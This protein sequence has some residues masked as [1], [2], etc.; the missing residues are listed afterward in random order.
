M[1]RVGLLFLGLWLLAAAQVV[2]A[3]EPEYARKQDVIYGR[4]YGLALTLDVFSPKTEPNGAGAILVASGGYFSSPDMINPIF[5]SELLKRGYTVFVV[6]HGSQPKFTLTEIVEDMH[7]AV[8]YIRSHAKEYGVDPQRL[9]IGGASA[10][11]HLSLMMGTAGTQGDPKA[12]DPVDRESSRVQAVACF[13]P[14]TDFLNW[15]KEGNELLGA[16]AH[17][18]R[19]RATF[20]HH[21]FDKKE[22]L[23][24]PVTDRQ[25]LRE[26]TKQV[27]P[28]WHVTA[29][30]APTLLIH[31]D[32]DDLVP[33]Q[34]SELMAAKLKGAK[35]ASELQVRKGAGHGWLTIAFD[36]KLFA[37]WY[38]K[39]LT[40]K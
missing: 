28:A 31:G 2:C 23:F 26:I 8:R 30:D 12:A 7:R 38:D 27:S 9:A 5:Y 24:L 29:D 34:Q 32:K 22:G 1:P 37:D 10:G 13:F 11:G 14:P 17:E 16:R 36:M 18:V 21:L 6:V 20:D 39:H 19:F 35:V 40:K 33:L 4:K 25:E 15:G 3:A